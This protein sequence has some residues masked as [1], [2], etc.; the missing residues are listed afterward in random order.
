MSWYWPAVAPHCQPRFLCGIN[1]S[2]QTDSETGYRGN[3]CKPQ[4]PAHGTSLVD[5]QA[6]C[7]ARQ[8]YPPYVPASPLGAISSSSLLP[9]VPDISVHHASHP[10]FKSSGFVLLCPA[11]ECFTGSCPCPL[12]LYTLTCLYPLP[13]SISPLT[14]IL[15]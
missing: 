3:V 1:C 9:A 2:P 8:A 13:R 5:T 6:G 15:V 4:H 12:G 11:C 10:S 7:S 14:C